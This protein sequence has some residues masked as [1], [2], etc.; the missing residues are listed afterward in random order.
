MCSVVERVARG[1]D[2]VP[3]G[4]RGVCSSGREK[5]MWCGV[6][7][8]A[9]EHYVPRALSAAC[10]AAGVSGGQALAAGRCVRGVP[11]VRYGGVAGARLALRGECCGRV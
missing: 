10:A 9:I 11:R 7:A 8:L 1:G 6:R 3:D 5:T 2:G 4:V